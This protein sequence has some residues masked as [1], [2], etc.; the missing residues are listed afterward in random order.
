MLLTGHV[1]LSL[2][3]VFW[4]CFSCAQW[5]IFYIPS[6]HRKIWWADYSECLDV[7]RIYC[8]WG[9]ANFLFSS[10]NYLC[11]HCM[12]ILLCKERKEFY[13]PSKHLPRFLSKRRRRSCVKLRFTLLTSV[14]EWQ[15][16]AYTNTSE[17][18]K[19]PSS[20]SRYQ[21]R[22]LRRDYVTICNFLFALRAHVGHVICKSCRRNRCELCNFPPLTETQSQLV[23][24]AAS[25]LMY[26]TS[27]KYL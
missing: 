20:V 10:I 27:H 19:S 14:L 17:Q 5:W 18:L 11:Y 26:T 3:T 6:Q 16:K 2:P 9:L 1:R 23:N 25:D 22:F 7:A 12:L 4:T 24:R 21:Q 8:C 13:C 15:E